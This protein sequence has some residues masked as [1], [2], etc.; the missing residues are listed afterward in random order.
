[1][2]VMDVSR[3]FG[4]N[5]DK[6]QLVIQPG[7]NRFSLD[8]AVMNYD[9]DNQYYYKLDGAMDNWQQNENGHLSFYSLSPGKYTLHVRGGNQFSDSPGSE[10]DVAIIVQPY[11]WQTTWFKLSCL[12]FAIAIATV[13]IRRRI[14]HI[15]HEASFKQKIAETEM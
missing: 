6:K 14:I 10:D 11:W 2:T 12:V 15:R 7:Q 5:S 3:L 8:F 1:A 13:L 4:F 9:G